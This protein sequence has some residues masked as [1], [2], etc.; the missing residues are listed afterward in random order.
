M[1]LSNQRQESPRQ[2]LDEGRTALHIRRMSIASNSFNSP[3]RRVRTRGAAVAIVVI[4]ATTI[5]TTIP[6]A[7]GAE[8]LRCSL[9]PLPTHAVIRVERD[10]SLALGGSD[11]RTA[12]SRRPAPDGPAAGPDTPMP[13]GRVR[14][15][16]LDSVTRAL[17]ATHGVTAREPT[18]YL[19]AAPYGADCGTVVYTDTVPFLIPGEQGYVQAILA[20]RGMWVGNVPVFIVPQVWSSPYPRRR[21]GGVPDTATLAPALSLFTVQQLLHGPL[22]TR[23][24]QSGDFADAER[25]RRKNVMAWA[26]QH[27]E[28]ADL[29][30]VRSLVRHAVLVDDWADAQRTPSRVRGTYRVEIEVDGQVH[31]WVFRT[32]PQ[33][34]YQLGEVEARLRTAALLQSP[35]IG[36]YRLVGTAA[37]SLG[38]LG[39]DTTRRV[40]RE[41]LVWLS[42]EDRVTT[43]GNEHRRRLPAVLEFVMAGS[44]PAV[45][46][47]VEPFAPPLMTGDSLMMAIMARMGRT[48]TRADKQPRLPLTLV[49]DDSG[50]VRAETTYVAARGAPVRRVRVSLVRLDTI[51]LRRTF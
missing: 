42:V 51:T 1:E 38:A 33:L 7:Q 27:L 35:H 50:G 6:T 22:P 36:G 19:K 31:G 12:Y 5:A 48:L 30:P 29:E 26:A 14:V 4:A 11:L 46:D 13:A 8:R 44:P 41:A 43:P 47:A 20:P 18:V 49:L 10:T 37:A 9:A 32:Q 24:P 2:G 3:S 15:L 28:E 25:Q 21:P 23:S 39:V 45:W 40:R 16:A 17:L 34:A